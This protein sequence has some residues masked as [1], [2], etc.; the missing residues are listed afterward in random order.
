MTAHPHAD[1]P[2]PPPVPGARP[3]DRPPE[4][5]ADPR[6][7][8]TQF[9][10]SVPP[11][12]A[13]PDDLRA[14]LAA[15]FGD[16]YEL[17]DKLGEG[18]FGAVYRGFDRRLNR[19][20]AVKVTRAE[21]PLHGDPAQLLTE[22][23]Q[24]AQLRHAGVVTVHDVGTGGRRC[25]VV[26]ELL[27]GPTLSAWLRGHRPIW[28]EA[29][30]IAA[31]VADALAHAHT[32]S[33]VH[34]D[35]KPSNV[36]LLDGRRPVLVDFG[37]ALSDA[38]AVGSR[39]VVVGT[40]EY[41]S[42]EQA[43]GQAHRPDGRTDVY[44][45]GV[46]L[47]EML[48]GRPPFRGEDSWLLL[49]AVQ[50]DDPQPPRQISPEVPPDVERI[51]LKAMAKLPADR[52]STAADLAADLRRAL[53]RTEPPAPAPP[54]PSRP[55][56]PEAPSTNLLHVP[57]AE[58]ETDRGRRTDAPGGRSP[59]EQARATAVAERR[60][61]TV[62][63]CWFEPPG[64]PEDVEAA[65][66]QFLAFRST[67]Q[68]VVARF[69]GLE[70]PT[71]GTTF[72][73]CFGYPVAREDA[74]RL[75]ARAGLQIAGGA[76]DGATRA[77]VHT[78]QA[79]VTATAAG[80]PEVVG[81]VVNVVSRLDAHCPPGRVVLT[82]AAH[83]LVQGYFDCEPAGA[84]AP[85]P[86]AP[87]A[88]LFLVA[89]ERAAHNRVEA[90]DP[91]RLTPLVG[92]D[93]EVGL[94]QER[95]E[96][97]AEG[98][99]H[100]V[101]LVADPGLGKSR[102]VRVIRDHARGSEPQ[103]DSDHI[104]SDG[105]AVVWY[106]SPYHA[107]SPFHPVID[108]FARALG[109]AREPDPAKRLDRLLTRLREEGITD[110]ERAALFASALSIPFAGRL[111]ELGLSA[112]RQ[113][114]LFRAAVL[115]WLRNR[116]ARRPVLFVVEDLHWIDPSTE[117]LLAE[118]VE[119]WHEAPILAVF[120]TRPEYEPPWKGRTHQTA[121]ALTRLTKRQIGEMVR[122]ATGR[123]DV[124]PEAVDRVAD[125]TD[126][127]PLFVEE[128]A[129]VLVE[130]GGGT[131]GSI[132]ATLR[133]LLLARLD[134]MASNKD[135]VQL[136]AAIGR[137]FS[138]EMLR[139]ACEL[140]ESA[141]RAELDKLV[142]AGVLFAKGAP[143]RTT[144]TFKHA[145]IQDAAYQSLVKRYRQQVHLRIAE[146]VERSFPDAA[147]TEPEVLAHHFTEAGHT[148]RA[149]GYWTRAGNRA[150]GRSAYAEAI[151]H[152]SRGLEL[153]AV[154]PEGPD[155][156][157]R[158]FGL[159]LPLGSCHLAASGYAAPP[160]EAEVVRV[161]DLCERLGPAFPLFDVMMVYWALRFIRGKNARAQEIGDEL[162]A[163]ADERDD[164]C[165]TEAHWACGCTAWWA[166]DFAGALEHLELAGELYR[167]EAAAGHAVYTQQNSGPLLTS[168]TGLALWALGRPDAA[169]K[170]A[171]EAVAFAE[172]LRHP[173]TRAV[174]A[175]Q[176]GLMHQLGGDGSGA[177]AE[178]ERALAI[179]R[180]QSFAFW[181][182]LATSLK[183]AA[184]GQLGRSAEAVP[185]LTD[186]LRGVEATGCEMVHQHF[187]GCLA[188]AL[189]ATGRRPEAW[190]A[191]D[192]ALA[193]TT[194][195]CERYVEAE[196]LRRKAAFLLDESPENEATATEHLEAALKVARGQGAKF[197]ELRAA[198]A[199]GRLWHSAGRTADARERVRPIVES[200]TEGL[201]SPD[202]VQ[203]R[204][205]LAG[206]R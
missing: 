72:L 170:K 111:P 137:T 169:R 193:L 36:I 68:D 157:A 89:G 21:R 186:G 23:R 105:P 166:G 99:G 101:L 97:A 112:E 4:H 145:L 116:A 6:H 51:V 48:C 199:L 191:L 18:G 202:V 28:A 150:R 98:M 108:S 37:I 158:E 66:E 204:E 100:V 79:V 136:G 63:Y 50:E 35:V 107:G 125:R 76:A 180:E 183:G 127:V 94:L 77:A 194:R 168:Y 188:D 148:E 86:G 113:R 20:V 176:T 173:F 58:R 163:L 197:F 126:G 192:R 96:Q 147:E 10:S 8:E 142:G 187:L 32:R 165:R 114:E 61:I 160:V 133:D 49:R 85:R 29:V 161:R 2:D 17:G 88:A 155:R 11:V 106:C 64:D 135:V 25:F 153:L 55:H 80:R 198:V 81:E 56:G 73:A 41:M 13:E 91:A 43:R 82:A 175:W 151:R 93:R 54:P 12:G 19:P 3:E 203:A 154:L 15:A 34:R 159:R 144:Y 52:Y 27:A 177:L 190:S 31:A 172:R 75:A 182:A 130:G 5:K 138:F 156:D 122:A 87:A 16:R 22:A 184:L 195:D 128:F 71:T 205:F 206:L 174:T 1:G 46:V 7:Q 110:P 179:A 123:A 62:L 47:Y 39:G 171:A 78:G 104:G 42:P 14:D 92:R 24:L 90:A 59:A 149:V 146:A 109:L 140:D 103:A 115:D 178:A 95:W 45:L 53:R 124:P 26:S 67:C 44:S 141:L 167:P 9:I 84:A 152:L 38:N 134:R 33:I 201:D 143:P 185:L 164:G 131:A 132:P 129:R 40:P 200:F 119:Q 181:I 117:E 102:L 60:Q 57:A 69:D 139:A 162:L 121:V 189:W 74:A 65:H 196:L 30:E 70:L 83:R 118:F 120:T